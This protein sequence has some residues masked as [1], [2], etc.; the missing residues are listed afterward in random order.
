MRMCNALTA[1]LG[2]RQGRDGLFCME[3]RAVTLNT[4]ADVQLRLYPFPHDPVDVA[5]QGDRIVIFPST[6]MLHR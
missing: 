2:Q 6:T 1:L 4:V 5:P 3:L